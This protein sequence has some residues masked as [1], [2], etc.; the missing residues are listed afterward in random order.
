MDF[1]LAFSPERED[2]GNPN[3][4]VATIPKIVGG[5]TPGCLKKAIEVYS[6]AIKELSACVLLSRRRGGQ[7]A[8][9]YIPEREYRIG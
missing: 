3:S 1:H 6:M 7:A 9:E 8:G 2:P 5:L 4:V